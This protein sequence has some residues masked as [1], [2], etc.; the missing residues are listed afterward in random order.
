MSDSNW[1]VTL[2]HTYRQP[3][4]SYF[5]VGFVGELFGESYPCAESGR[6]IQSVT[7]GKKDLCLIFRLDGD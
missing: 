5:P 6:I 7:A 3:L 1:Y 4:N 2:L